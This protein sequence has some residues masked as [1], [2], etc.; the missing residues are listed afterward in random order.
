MTAV[1]PQAERYVG[2]GVARKE[3]PELLT[4]EARYIDDLVLPGTLWFALVRS[5]FAH[6]RIGGVDLSA[7]SEMPGV[8]AAFSGADLADE[9]AAGLPCAWPIARRSFPDPTTEDPRVPDHFPLA[10]ERARYAGDAVAV[11]VAASRAEAKDAL[12]A[13]QVD[14]EPLDAALG[15]EEALADGAPLVHEEIDSNEAY[16]WTL[17][18][19]DAVE[20]IFAEAPV[21]IQERYLHPRL[22]PNAIEPRGCLVEP[23]PAQGEY[24]LW[25][26]T[27]VPHIAKIT[28]SLTTGIPESKLRVIAPAVGGGFGSKLNVYAEEALALALARRLGAPVK[29]V[30][31]RSEDYL[32]TIHGRSQI[33]E[34]ELAA[35]EEGKVR[36][37]R[38]R[39][40]ADMGAYMQLVTPGVPL[41][42]AFLYA[43]LYD[44]EAY[45][46]ECTGVFTHRTPTDAYR[47]AGRPEA[48]YAIERAM[49]TLARR[50][51][52]DPAEIRRQ[53]FIPPFSEP[54]EVASGLQYDSGNYQAALDRAL[55]L[56]DYE[57]VR[58]EQASR[59]EGG[60]AKPLGIGL[61]S[62][63]EI[64]GLAPSQVLAAL[65]Y[66]AGGWD[67]AE[68]RCHPT[69]KVTVITGTS[70][71]GQGHVTTWA[72]I[73]ADELGVP[74]DDV[75]VLHGDTAVAPLGMDTYGS[76]SLAVGGI[77]LWNAAQRVK[78]K[79][80]KIAAH[81][82]E[83]AEDD[84]EWT[85]GRFQV[86]GVPASTKTIPE[87]AFS[88][89]TAHNLPE[90]V[91]P[92][93]AATYVFDPPNF[94]FPN[95]THVCVVEVDTETGGVEIVKYVAVDDCGNQINPVI[96]EGQVH[97]G[98]A[99][100]IAEAMFEEAIYDEQGQLLTAAMHSYRIPSAAE[101]PRFET[102]TTVTP[103][104]TNPMGVKGVGE[105]AT[106]GAPPAVV[107]A[108]IDALAPLGVT[109]IDKPV[110]P[111]RVWRAIQDAKG[112]AS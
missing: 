102:D 74:I 4:G 27:Q 92:S 101:L 106:I 60:D 84:V 58:S 70:P 26:A 91:E 45:R 41:L 107:N 43:G 2:R 72:Q 39:I 22:I 87:I 34:M 82:L 88:A 63:I 66:G 77:A 67:A 47:G 14:W 73:T 110:T 81:E 25:S 24:T 68:V 55:E 52:R 6:A 109:T 30:V 3:D 83:V 86:R 53:N 96:V 97:G 20:R 93:L 38:A 44:V 90:G 21:I 23:R 29:W 105:A 65:K 59:R 31:D 33:Q 10:T 64:C 75:E 36:A 8:V 54:R 62:Y 51:G 9:W 104:S 80:L 50:L 16:T 78:A 71:H 7:A 103:S 11:V 94:T 48:T 111:E 49:D 12:E 40:W 95:G 17:G 89:W 35:T 18:D 46:F 15:I 32:A 69:G 37:V 57:S 19:A 99:Q 79:A 100:G 13:V 98:A 76:R 85:N 5:P 112:G 56:V 28:L 61:S 108:V 42:G 1:E